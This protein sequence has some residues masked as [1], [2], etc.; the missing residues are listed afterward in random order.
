[1]GKKEGFDQP[2][3]RSKPVQKKIS[4]YPLG[5]SEPKCNCFSYRWVLGIRD[6]SLV[7]GRR[8]VIGAGEELK[9]GAADKQHRKQAEA[10]GQAQELLLAQPAQG[11]DPEPSTGQRR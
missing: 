5:W 1:M 9:A 4:D 7:V 3:R 2:P 10:Q 8:V 6:D 11:C